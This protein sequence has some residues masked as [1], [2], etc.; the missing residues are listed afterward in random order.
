MD[1]TVENKALP[2]LTKA[3]RRLLVPLV[4]II[5]RNGV[6]YRA[7]MEEAVPPGSDL[8]AWVAVRMTGSYLCQWRAPD[9]VVSTARY[10]LRRAI[11]VH[12]TAPRTRAVPV[13][14]SHSMA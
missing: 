3:I 2:V 10:S 14:A 5:L 11:R 6:S 1:A 13:T 8:N 4:K 7:F 9:L 12:T